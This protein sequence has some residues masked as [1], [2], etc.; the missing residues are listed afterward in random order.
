MRYNSYF[1]FILSYD[2][3]KSKNKLNLFYSFSNL[4]IKSLENFSYYEYLNSISFHPPVMIITTLV[5]FFIRKK[6]LLDGKKN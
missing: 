6:F 5:F 3:Y 1:Q 2:L 4:K